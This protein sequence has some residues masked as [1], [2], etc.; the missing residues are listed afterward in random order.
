[1]R[2]ALVRLFKRHY[3][4]DEALTQSVAVLQKAKNSNARLALARGAGELCMSHPQYFAIPQCI[5]SEPDAGSMP[6]IPDDAV[7]VEPP[8]TDPKH[9]MGPAEPV[10]KIM[11]QR[12]DM[13]TENDLKI[14]QP[15]VATPQRVNVRS[16]QVA[17]IRIC[18]LLTMKNC[19]LFPK[20]CLLG[21]TS[22]EYP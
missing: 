20:H 11:R 22:S 7:P 4:S 1:M 19:S 15:L 18:V 17:I 10:A 14:N 2:A 13:D 12:L 9:F 8:T 6:D 16:N 5:L 3:D 21:I